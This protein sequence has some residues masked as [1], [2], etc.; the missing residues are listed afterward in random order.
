MM[1]WWVLKHNSC[2]LGFLLGL[3]SLLPLDTLCSGVSLLRLILSFRENILICPHS[4]DKSMIIY[5]RNFTFGLWS[6]W[7]I[8]TCQ[9]ACIRLP[10][11][12]LHHHGKSLHICS[13]CSRYSI[14]RNSQCWVEVSL[15]CY[16]LVVSR[17]Y[18]IINKW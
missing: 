13:L 1:M 4:R 14:V 3:I 7:A 10:Y 9:Y 16:L 11:L 8:T 5:W 6:I 2:L 18:A 12:R 17:V 15:R